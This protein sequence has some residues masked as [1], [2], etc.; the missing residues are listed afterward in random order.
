MKNGKI[1]VVLIAL[2]SI[3]ITKSYGQCDG[4]SNY[5]AGAD[6]AKKDHVLYR[7]Y[8]KRAKELK[9]D[10]TKSKE[11]ITAGLTEY[12]GKAFEKWEGLYASSAGATEW[13]PLDGIE[14]YSFFAKHEED[15]DKKAAHHAKV[16]SI[17]DDY[18]A[19]F[20]NK[21][22]R[23]GQ[24]KSVDLYRRKAT[25]MMYYAKAD[26]MDTYN[27]Y[28]KYLAAAGDDVKPSVYKPFMYVAVKLF[29]QDSLDQATMREHYETMTSIAEAK[30]EEGV[31]GFDKALEDVKKAFLPIEPEVFD[32]AF[33]VEKYAPVFSDKYNDIDF[34][35]DELLYNLKK[36]N[37]TETDEFVLKVAD[38]VNHLMDSTMLANRS[39]E[40]WARIALQEKRYDDAID[41]YLKAIDE[42]TDNAEKAEMA[43]KAAYYTYIK[44]KDFSTARDHA[45]TAINY[46]P[47]WG[48][49]YLL[50]GDMYA[51]SGSKCG[52]GT[53]FNSQRVTW[54][55]IDKWN[56]A[57]AVDS[58]PE[59]QERANTQIA[60][61]T[62]FMP[63]KETL[64][65]IGLTEGSSYFV[66]CWIQESTTVRAYN[67]YR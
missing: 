10:K 46:N 5:P 51:S 61:Y 27:T 41:H 2:I 21:K 63:D 32:C 30:V 33:F 65:T 48:Q 13:H 44:K 26:D 47:N 60:K 52:S 22:L 24:L 64:H 45:R 7:D 39:Q 49:P 62:K 8:M 59:I 14:M 28:L 53:G 9:K 1:I 11:E 38:R 12:Y 25:Y 31:K 37:C 58:D 15:A 3:G 43:Y 36:G 42:K 54:V 16:L 20:G 23:S 18:I 67:P 29:K 17:Y 4:F 66:P 50:I 35:K 56:K 34:L 19:C 57:K 40:N 6:E 55:A